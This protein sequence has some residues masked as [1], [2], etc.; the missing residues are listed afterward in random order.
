MT[1]QLLDGKLISQTIQNK[2]KEK[3][4]KLSIKP[5]LA[6]VLIGKDSASQ[7]YVE[8]K[9]KACQ[10]IGYYSEKIVL[11]ETASHDVICQAIQRLNKDPK[12]HGILVQFPLPKHLEPLEEKIINLINPEKDVDG[13]HPIN[14]GKLLSAKNEQISKAVLLPCTPKGIVRLLKEYHVPLEGAHVVVC[15]RSN[16]VGKPVALMALLAGATVSICHSKTQNLSTITKQAD[17][18]IAAIGKPRFITESMV[19]SGAIVIDV[20]MNRGED[21]KITGDVDFDA[22]KEKIKAITPVP[23]GVGPLTI[24]M[25]ME[26]VY[27]AYKA[28]T[29]NKQKD[30]CN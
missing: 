30:I 24:A 6:V 14:S 15:G 23:G 27:Q 8:N 19:K 13:F 16:L 18:L 5:G 20:G 21:K 7:I 28:Q 10:E 17:I 9:V 26:N 4:Q 1:Y 2:L 12:I 22:V 11:L 25:L 3:V 29:K